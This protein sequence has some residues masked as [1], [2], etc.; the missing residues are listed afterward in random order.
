MLRKILPSILA[1]TTAI[2]SHGQVPV[3]YQ[4]EAQLLVQTVKGFHFSPR[5]VDNKFSDWV[6][7]NMMDELDPE[8]IYFTSAQVSTLKSKSHIIDD[9]LN[10][11][12]WTFLPSLIQQYTTSLNRI[13][14]MLEKIYTEP[15][16]L[17]KT[18]D[19]SIDTTWSE[20]ETELAERWRRSVKLDLLRRYNEIRQR[21]GGK[22][23]ANFLKQYDSEARSKSKKIVMRSALRMKNS[24]GGLENV[25]S[26]MYLNTVAK[27]FDPHTAYLSWIDM[28]N[29]IS[30]LSSKGLNFGLALDEN[31]NG[32]ISIE[33]LAPGGPAWNSGVL[34]TG[35][36]IR[37]LKWQGKEA[38][39]VTGMDP[40]ELE[41]ILMEENHNV[42]SVTVSKPGGLL[43]TTSLKKEVIE[44][45]ENIV[46]SFILEG[47]RKIG[48]ISLPGF[49]T[50]W[51]D[52]GSECA[53]DVATEII[54]LKKEGIE[55][56]ILD[57]R[58][59]GGGSLKEAVALAGIF[60]D[61]GPIG[62]T[63]DKAGIA[64]TVKDINRGTVYDGPLMVM[65]NP[66][67]ASAS[68]FVAAALQDY[69]RAIVVGGRT[70]GKATAQ[71][72]FPLRPN[73]TAYTTETKFANGIGHASITLEKIYRVNGKTA[74]F[75]GVTPAI[76]IPEVYDSLA[77]WE[78]ML[79]MAL[80][81][82]SVNKK[83]Y[84][85][86]LHLMPIPELKAKSEKRISESAKFKLM[87]NV[88][89]FLKSV[90]DSDEFT[91]VNW[92]SFQSLSDQ[93]AQIVKSYLSIPE[94]SKFNVAF[95]QFDNERMSSDSFIEEYNRTWIKKL[96]Q[97]ISLEEGFAIICD[98]ISILKRESK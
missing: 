79:P 43:Q 95:H 93:Y 73:A 19:L 8:R 33:R 11:R 40:R 64:Q 58:F 55:G 5:P 94:T 27:A 98:Y 12:G 82:D 35:D 76:S 65:V 88:Q 26:K 91:K 78:S 24:S 13:P 77:E 53:N 47:E 2:A 38:V 18:E 90:D 7:N 67:S 50:N 97:D 56:L 15:F 3:N 54:K 10:G 22:A 83:A 92:T 29:F 39:D 69:R 70:Y 84:Y 1:F 86:P 49:Y 75:S 44:N 80:P 87:Y 51:G 96:K 4:K 17:G 42:L 28:E 41:Q 36:V 32:E 74:Q 68:E 52:E 25:I 71:A 61:A 48:F 30:G 62:I 34:N 85:T 31:D 72:L 21:K 45:D 16:D 14:P 60:I 37:E 66:F 57:L 23:D 89:A 20:D 59:N 6:F 63:K 9:E 46:K 81:K